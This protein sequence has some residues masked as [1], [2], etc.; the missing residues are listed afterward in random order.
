MKLKAA[1]I[2]LSLTLLACPTSAAPD[3]FSGDYF[4]DLNRCGPLSLQ[5]CANFVEL[6]VGRKEID[7]LLPPDGQQCSLLEL[8]QAAEKLG[9]HTLAV[10]WRRDF[11]SITSAPAIIPIQRKAGHSHFVAVVGRQGNKVCVV[12]VPHDPQWVDLG[13][14]YEDL[15]WDGHAVHV[16]ADAAAI[17]AVRRYAARPSLLPRLVGVAATTSLGIMGCLVVLHL[18]RRRKLGVRRQVPETV[19]PASADCVLP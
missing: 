11:P 8:K 16:A 19:S 14:L 2:S 3:L 6:E 7:V 18:R 5:A 15:K 4:G 12:D 10:R 1:V 9:L 17:E 13:V